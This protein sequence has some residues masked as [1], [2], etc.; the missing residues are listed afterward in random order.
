M[1]KEKMFKLIEALSSAG[2]EILSVKENKGF[3]D[4][5]HCPA[6]IRLKIS[7]IEENTIST[8]SGKEQKTFLQAFKD[9]TQFNRS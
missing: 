3:P 2:Y 1:T 6:I 4:L 8:P 9:E 5:P 7:P